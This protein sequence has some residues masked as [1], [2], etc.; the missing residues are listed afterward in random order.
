MVQKELVYPLQMV[1]SIR[2][3]NVMKKIVALLLVL[4][5]AFGILSACQNNK[6][7]SK[8]SASSETKENVVATV[9]DEVITED[10]M[11]YMIGFVKSS[12]ITGMEGQALEDFWNTLID[13]VDPAD[14]IRKEAFEILV[15]RTLLAQV[16]NDAG[17]TVAAE[18]IDGFFTQNKDMT[19]NIMD[20]YGV[21]EESLKAIYRKELLYGK[22]DQTVLA[23]DER[24]NPTDEQ[25]KEIFQKDYYKAQ[26]ILKMT[27][28]PETNEPLSQEEKDA[29]RV[30]IDNILLS[31][32]DGA[33]FEAMMQEHNEDPGMEQLPGGYVFSK[34]S[35]MA[36]EFYE[37]TVTLEENSISEVIETAFGYHII[38][39]LPLDVDADLEANREQ[40]Q[41]MY[42][43][44]EVAKLVEELRGSVE[45]KTDEAKLK[46]IA[47]K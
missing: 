16:A 11:K 36:P 34:Y 45:I 27:V 23:V 5:L 33:D 47:V 31:L 37:A 13:G 12:M 6:D 28:N 18:E 29:A 24:Y 39:R 17:I 19:A 21:S 20:T 41:D 2:R 1:I 25:L 43:E 7:D 46:E 14:Y 15:D 40:V 8:E 10:E 44:V 35:G 4:V 22:Y 38:K 30:E 42:K 32:K 9:G 26:H 3:I